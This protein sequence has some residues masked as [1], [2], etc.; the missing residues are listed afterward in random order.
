MTGES[1]VIQSGVERARPC[2]EDIPTLEEENEAEAKLQ[3]SFRMEK[4][5]PADSPADSPA[6]DSAAAENQ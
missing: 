3:D 2:D 5:Q 1:R 4:S 6:G